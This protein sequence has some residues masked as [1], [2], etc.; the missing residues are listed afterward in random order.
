[1]AVA[2]ELHFGRAAE[3]LHMAAP[4]LSELIRRLERE[5][6]TPLFTRTTRRVALTSAGAELLARSKVILDEVAAADAA[7]RRVAGGDAG[8]VR[9]GITPP[10]GPVLAP[11][12]ISRFA[13]EAPQ[14][15]VDLRRMWLPSL[16]EALLSGQVDAAMTCGLIPAPEGTANEVFCAEPL[17]VGLRPDHRLAGRDVVALADL[18]R[19]VLGITP[20]DLFPAWTLS[21]RQALET[22]GIS[23]PVI[24]LAGTDLAAIGWAEQPDIEWIML[25]PSLAAAHTTTVVRPVSSG[26]LVPFTLQWN[27]N[28]THTT[29]V[30][31]FVHTVL[32]TELPPGWRTQPG[33][34]RHRD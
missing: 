5:L 3:R 8:V 1:V 14:V 23:P 22:A 34:L 9:L 31:R 15:T 29:A 4:T 32:T 18:A 13:A 28:R 6:G 21:Q 10:V 26:Q 16:T 30:A 12:L 33:H 11:Y 17:L 25:I 24:D 7:V 20:A 2:T 27:P 19:D